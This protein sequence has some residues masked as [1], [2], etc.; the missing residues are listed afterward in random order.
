MEVWSIRQQMGNFV[1]V[2]RWRGDDFWRQGAT[3]SL[4]CPKCTCW[5]TKYGGR[6]CPLS[7]SAVWLNA[8]KDL[9]NTLICLFVHQHSFAL[10]TT[11]F[12]FYLRSFRG[13]LF[14]VF[15]SFFL[16]IYNTFV[17]PTFFFC[18]AYLVLLSLSQENVIILKPSIRWLSFKTCM[19]K[20]LQHNRSVG[21]WPVCLYRRGA[22]G[23]S[24]ECGYCWVSSSIFDINI[25]EK[26]KIP[27]CMRVT[28][29]H[30]SHGK[31]LVPCYTVSP[32]SYLGPDFASSC[33]VQFS[34]EVS[35]K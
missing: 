18:A 15:C 19:R 10:L 27:T 25:F 4:K 2:T 24:L 11:T 20:A 14:W 34:P 21:A 22:R 12:H 16:P 32:G 30:R 5:R 6:K 28:L 7:T 35:K 13:K 26:Y 23:I 33:R 31:C 9:L 8:G 3:V 17:W 1:G 29:G